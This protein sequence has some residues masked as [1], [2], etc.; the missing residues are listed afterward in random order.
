MEAARAEAEAYAIARKARAAA[1]FAAATAGV[2]AEAVPSNSA[3]TAATTDSEPSASSSSSSQAPGTTDAVVVPRPKARRPVMAGQ[4]AAG[5]L[6]LSIECSIRGA[7][8]RLALAPVEEAAEQRGF[9]HELEGIL[10]AYKNGLLRDEAL[11]TQRFDTLPV[12]VAQAHLL[13]QDEQ[14]NDTEATSDE[15]LVVIEHLS[16]AVTGGSKSRG[17]NNNN[18]RRHRQSA[19]EDPL[20]LSFRNARER[21]LAHGLVQWHQLIASSHD[22]PSSSPNGHPTRVMSVRLPKAG[23]LLHDARLVKYMHKLGKIN[24]KALMM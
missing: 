12:Q 22:V 2:A 5:S 9:L 6:F 4:E 21:F 8:R 15:D 3:A 23:V 13:D 19:G 1:K 24:S 16:D 7:L 14:D 17:S 11:C 10:V 20:H 18:N